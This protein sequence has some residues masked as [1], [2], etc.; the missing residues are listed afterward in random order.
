MRAAGE[1]AIVAGARVSAVHPLRAVGDGAGPFADDGPFVA[2]SELACFGAG[3]GDVLGRGPGNLVRAEDLVCM[4]VEHDVVEAGGLETV[5]VAYA[6]ECVVD[7]R[8]SVGVGVADG[9]P[10]VVVVLFE[11]VEVDCR[12][13]WLVEE[14]DG[15][16]DVGVPRVT[17]G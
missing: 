11:F 3:G 9:A 6:L 8:D 12:W 15:R 2:A 17:L 16:H 1:G 13:E 4:Y 10:A 7:D 14:L 5:P